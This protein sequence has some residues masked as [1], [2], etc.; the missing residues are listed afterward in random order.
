MPKSKRSI[1][2]I[3]SNLFPFPSS[4][5][6][7]RG[8][9]FQ[10]GRIKTLDSQNPVFAFSNPALGVQSNARPTTVRKLSSP[11]WSTAGPVQSLVEP[12]LPGIC[13]VVL[14]TLL[15][16]SQHLKLVAIVLM[17]LVYFELNMWIGGF[18]SPQVFSGKYVLVWAAYLPSWVLGVYV[19][20]VSVSWYF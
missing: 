13:G 19:Y 10:R 16:W 14:S 6:L 12:A 7:Q 8:D 4:I 11:R 2:L 17:F 1:W 3:N 5:D 15:S 20:M 18:A 9:G